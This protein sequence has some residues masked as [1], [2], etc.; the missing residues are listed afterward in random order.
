MIWNII[1]YKYYVII[2]WK[3]YNDLPGPQ[4]WNETEWHSLFMQSWDASDILVYYSL[5]DLGA[6]TSI[7]S[8][9]AA[10]TV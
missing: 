7:T 4:T 6:Y 8:F 2:Y 9:F 1:N 10:L 5:T 3:Y